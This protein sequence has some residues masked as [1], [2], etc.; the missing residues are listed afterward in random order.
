MP[1]HGRHCVSTRLYSAAFSGWH[2]RQ[3]RKLPLYVCKE[4]PSVTGGFRSQTDNNTKTVFMLSI[5]VVFLYINFSNTL[6]H[7]VSRL[8][9]SRL[10]RNG[11]II[12]S[13]NE[14]VKHN[15]WK[16]CNKLGN[17]SNQNTRAVITQTLVYRFS[18]MINHIINSYNQRNIETAQSMHVYGFWQRVG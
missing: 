18:N 10:P 5:C 16:H 15:P 13:F 12:L 2:H 8:L 14:F 4:N 1:S 9:I 3:H 6:S 11:V 7:T 17:L